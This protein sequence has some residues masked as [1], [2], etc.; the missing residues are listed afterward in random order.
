MSKKQGDRMAEAWRAMLP[1]LNWESYS[2][3]TARGDVDVGGLSLWITPPKRRGHSYR[4]SVQL[5]MFSG[6]VVVER[7]P[8]L[9]VAMGKIQRGLLDSLEALSAAISK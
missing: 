4:V 1:G 3:G 2:D 7:D 9:S 8:D 5:R 6:Q